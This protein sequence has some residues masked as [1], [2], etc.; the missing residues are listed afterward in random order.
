MRTHKYTNND[1]ISKDKYRNPGNFSRKR[2]LQ[3]VSEGEFTLDWKQHQITFF[4]SKNPT[5]TYV[6]TRSFE[7]YTYTVDKILLWYYI[8]RFYYT[9]LLL[10]F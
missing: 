1:K 9:S 2:I 4:Q 10:I 6:V 8:G 5:P 3:I 7:S